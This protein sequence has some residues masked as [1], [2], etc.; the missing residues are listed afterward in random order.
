MLRDPLDIEEDVRAAL[1]GDV[2]IRNPHLI[3]VSVDA[4]DAV[5]LRGAVENLPERR[6][7]V[8]DARGVDG[9]FDVVDRLR[10]HPPVS[11]RLADDAIRAAALQE[12]ASDPRIL[13]RHIH[14]SVEDGWITLRGYVWHA[15]QRGQAAAD[16]AGLDGVAG[17]TNRIRVE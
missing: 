3:A 5:V 15:S 13:E 12:L 6:A 1:R 11:G 14:V 9:V 17:V 4:I 7:A 10:I 8:R 2:R 16:V